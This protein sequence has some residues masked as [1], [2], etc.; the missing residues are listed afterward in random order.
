VI[1]TSSQWDNVEAIIPLS[2][3]QKDVNAKIKALEAENA[4]LSAAVK[5]VVKNKRTGTRTVKTLY[6]VNIERQAKCVARY[7]TRAPRS[8]SLMFEYHQVQ[9]QTVTQD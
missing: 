2:S 4:L 1:L 5:V 9:N 8:N 6:Q 3:Y 7:W